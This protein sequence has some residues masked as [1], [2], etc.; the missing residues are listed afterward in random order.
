MKFKSGETFGCLQFSHKVF[1]AQ[2]KG[3]L[4]QPNW[5]PVNYKYKLARES[6]DPDLGGKIFF[7]DSNPILIWENCWVKAF[8]KNY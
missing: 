8:L 6:I 7:W 2:R 3:T 5:K 1:A 4:V